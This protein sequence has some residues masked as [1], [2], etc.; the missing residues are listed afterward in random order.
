MIS[1]NEY[2]DDYLLD[3]YDFG[4]WGMQFDKSATAANNARL[5]SPKVKRSF[6]GGVAAMILTITLF[7]A[8]LAA[9]GYAIYYALDDI[10][11]LRLSLM[12]GPA[13]CYMIYR[14]FVI[15]E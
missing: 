13:N 6:F 10:A 8:T 1:Q 11:M 15:K 5:Q 3:E 2:L 7:V 12:L 4:S 9:Y 14:T